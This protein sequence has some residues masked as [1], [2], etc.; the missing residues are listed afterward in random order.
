[1]GRK[2]AVEAAKLA[3]VNPWKQHSWRRY[4]RALLRQCSY[5]PDPVAKCN[6]HDYVVQRFR[7]Y[8]IEE[9]RPWIRWNAER[10]I[11]LF[12]EAKDTLSL[13]QRANAG[14]S[15][16]L[17]KVIRMAY[18]RKGRRRKELLSALIAPDVPANN[19][20]VEEALQRPEKYE[21]GWEPPSIVMELLKSQQ[22]NGIL[23]QLNIRQ[24]KHL[25]PPIPKKCIWGDGVAKSR[26]RN[27]R[28]DWYTDVLDHLLPPLPDPDLGIL[29]GLVSGE[30]PWNPPEWRTPVNLSDRQKKIRR[31]TRSYL[32]TLLKDG[33]VKGPTFKPYSKGRPHIITRRFMQRIWRRTLCLIPHMEWDETAK[34]HIF[35][36]D[37]A[38]PTPRLGIPGGPEIFED[39]DEQGKITTTPTGLLP[40]AIRDTGRKP[41][42]ETP[43]ELGLE[44]KHELNEPR[45]SRPHD[46]VAFGVKSKNSSSKPS[47]KP[48]RV[49]SDKP[50]RKHDR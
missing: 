29:K 41:Y 31:L 2:E 4:F 14:Y 50:P 43:F 23:S 11:F 7:R 9:R 28:K 16:P 22:N 48:S 3:L 40:G 46:L 15:K 20:A 19:T 26:R 45:S 42:R 18:G 1:M 37:P 13:L 24:V 49:P 47:E 33:P 17:E 32:R 30:T 8:V 35:T 27:I 38:K 34:K 25:E 44:P 36:W 39:V 6:L 21:D 12:N 5:L 10:Q